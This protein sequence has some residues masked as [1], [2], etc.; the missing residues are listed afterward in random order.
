MMRFSFRAS[1]HKTFINIL[2]LLL[3]TV[4]AVLF[5]PIYDWLSGAIL[6]L[7]ICI[8]GFSLKRELAFL[9]KPEFLLLDAQGM[10]VRNRRLHRTGIY[11]LAWTDC[12]YAYATERETTEK[13]QFLHIVYYDSNRQLSLLSLDLSH[14][15]IGNNSDVARMRQARNIAEFINA[16]VLPDHAYF[17]PQILPQLTQSHEWKMHAP[18]YRS[19]C[20][21]GGLSGIL[22]TIVSF[23]ILGMFSNSKNFAALLFIASFMLLLLA[24][25]KG[26]TR[27]T[28]HRDSVLQRR[29]EIIISERQG[30]RIWKYGMP[31]NRS[32]LLPWQQI[33]GYRTLVSYLNA[34]YVNNN[35]VI[36][37]LAFQ[38][39]PNVDFLFEIALYIEG[40]TSN[41]NNRMLNEIVRI[42]QE[43]GAAGSLPYQEHH[44]PL[45]YLEV[46]FHTFGVN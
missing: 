23:A 32:L 15:Q 44:L 8:N 4:V 46:D 3:L 30:L 26:A 36:L 31:Y 18:I 28:M 43:Y 6:F 1:W 21:V 41:E 37:F 14:M 17:K 16:R 2:F 38:P 22:A 25:L 45:P 11:R 5:Y 33:R 42:I 12:R 39:H 40:K 9:L 24:L 19:G 27:T 35:A 20:I 13:F 7:F 29:P 10:I 34:G